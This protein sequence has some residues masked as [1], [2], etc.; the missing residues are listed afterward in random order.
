MPSGALTLT[1]V[2]AVGSWS[3]PQN[4]LIL[5][6]TYASTTTSSASL[7]YSTDAAVFM[8]SGATIVGVEVTVY[9]RANAA[10][11]LVKAGPASLLSGI[12]TQSVTAI[13]PAA[14]AP[15]TFG[16]PA[17][18]LGV[19]S[20]SQLASITVEVS[21]STTT[22]AIDHVEVTV[23][24]S[25]AP[26][27]TRLTL[28]ANPT[29]YTNS[30]WTTPANALTSNNS[31]ASQALSGTSSRLFAYDTNASSVIP[32][33]AVISGVVATV[34]S[35]VS[36]ASYGTLVGA[37]PSATGLGGSIN[38]VGVT[39]TDAVYVYGASDDP[40][41]ATSL[42][43]LATLAV[44]A[45]N[46]TSGTATVYIDHATMTVYWDYPTDGTHCMFFGENF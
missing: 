43:S 28:T 18:T 30:N 19:T 1:Y 32:A 10:G 42:A 20:I 38:M 46:A 11:R 15:I 23:H 35:R 12:A 14:V 29:G 34:E 4:S 24:W 36:V 33:N 5:D 40:L 2:S 16:G 31:Y 27:A 45:Q 8:P 3:G 37:S 7:T 22:V 17:D 21:N 41:G 39:T 6:A 13:S 9:A 44:R 25:G 26:N